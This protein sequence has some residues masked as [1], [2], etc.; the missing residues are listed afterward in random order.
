MILY[1]DQIKPNH[2]DFMTKSTDLRD[3]TVDYR[4]KHVDAIGAKP[5]LP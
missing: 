4:F 2:E 3:G 1:N 5:K